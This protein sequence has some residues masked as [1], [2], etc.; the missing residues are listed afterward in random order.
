MLTQPGRQLVNVTVAELDANS[1]GDVQHLNDQ[2]CESTESHSA[3]TP[4]LHPTTKAF[5]S[6]HYDDN[7][8]KAGKGPMSVHHKLW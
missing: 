3:P 1:T 2:N 8:A 4:S 6:F 7:G 5:K